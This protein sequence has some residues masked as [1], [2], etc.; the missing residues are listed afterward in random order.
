M[1]YLRFS[2][3]S[4]KA[5]PPCGAAGEALTV[6]WQG[7]FLRNGEEQPITGFKHYENP[8]CISEFPASQMDIRYGDQLMRLDFQV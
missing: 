1:T 5:T 2:R 6:G 3:T 8:Y 7:A 4:G